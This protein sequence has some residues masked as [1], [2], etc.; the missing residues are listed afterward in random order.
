MLYFL[1]IFT[2]RMFSFSL[3]LLCD[4]FT[5]KRGWRYLKVKKKNHY[6][7]PGKNCLLFFKI[8]IFFVQHPKTKAKGIQKIMRL[9]NDDRIVIFR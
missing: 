8:K 7:N 1:T 9:G 4:G 2:G 5:G 3:A 6:K